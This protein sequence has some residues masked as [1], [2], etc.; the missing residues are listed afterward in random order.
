MEINI[1]KNEITDDIKALQETL[2]KKPH[3]ICTFPDREVKEVLPTATAGKFK[4]S[5]SAYKLNACAILVKK[6]HIYMMH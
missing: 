4:I 1:K 6:K 5:Y 2:P 3:P